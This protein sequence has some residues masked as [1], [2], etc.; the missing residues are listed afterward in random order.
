MS[1]IYDELNEMVQQECEKS[2]GFSIRLMTY[3]TFAKAVENCNKDNYNELYEATKSMCRWW[4]EYI[5]K[6]LCGLCIPIG[7]TESIDGHHAIDK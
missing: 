5:S 2:N 1:Q 3:E 6:L 7:E 4:P